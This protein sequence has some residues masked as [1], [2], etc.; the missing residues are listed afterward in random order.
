MVVE[1]NAFC[2]WPRVSYNPTAALHLSSLPVVPNLLADDDHVSSVLWLLKTTS[3]STTQSSD[4]DT[5]VAVP[6]LR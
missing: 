3:H 4:M 6:T 2:R 5:K 1:R